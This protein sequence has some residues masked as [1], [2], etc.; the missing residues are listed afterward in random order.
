MTPPQDVSAKKK[1][2]P[3]KSINK[4]IGRNNRLSIDDWLGAAFELL[5]RE[6][7]NEVKI[8]SLCDVLGVTKGSFYW[9]FDDIN[10][11]LSAVADRWCAIQKQS[12]E[13][14]NAIKSQPVEERLETM[15]NFLI[16]ENIWSVEIAVREWSR[17]DV[18]VA[19]SV[20]ALDNQI[21]TVVREALLEL[22]FDESEA[23]LRAGAIVYAGIGFLHGRTSL[24]T[25]TEGELQS[26]FRIL[27]RP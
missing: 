21:F 24:P 11:L 10:A 14:I 16:D 13:A 25:P 9:H 2:T 1:S 19:E 27:T 12:V 22:N 23:R 8:S 15:A 20:R 17:S 7:I 26:I 4:K 3:K 6:G 18:K 5:V